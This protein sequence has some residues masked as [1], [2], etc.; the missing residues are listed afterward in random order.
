[1]NM[2]KHA[3]TASEKIKKIKTE[4]IRIKK[5]TIKLYLFFLVFMTTAIILREITYGVFNI[6]VDDWMKDPESHRVRDMWNVL[7]YILPCTFLSLACGCGLVAIVV[8]AM[9]ALSA[10]L[11]ILW[12]KRRQ[13]SAVQSVRGG[14]DVTL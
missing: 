6:C 9:A 12:C 2:D 8:D 11:R 4:E 14:D 13:Y 5:M 7:M 3:F 10:G 1:M